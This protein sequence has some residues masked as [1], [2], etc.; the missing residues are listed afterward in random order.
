M[1]SYIRKQ[2]MKHASEFACYQYI[3][4]LTEG[5][6]SEGRPCDYNFYGNHLG[7]DKSGTPIRPYNTYEEGLMWYRSTQPQLDDWMIS[8]IVYDNIKRTQHPHIETAVVRNNE[9]AGLTDEGIRLKKRRDRLQ[10]R[11]E[12][13]KRGKEGIRRKTAPL[14][15]PFLLEFDTGNEKQNIDNLMNL[16]ELN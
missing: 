9:F 8:Q 11:L 2:E 5:A 16:I 1:T 13:R 4:S 3:Q 14:D 15:E 10:K 6:E 7:F 12:E